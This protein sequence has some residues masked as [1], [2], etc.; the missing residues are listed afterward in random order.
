MLKRMSKDLKHPF[1][2]R[3]LTTYQSPNVCY[4]LLELVQ[5]GELFSRLTCFAMD[6]FPMD[7]AKFYAS[8]TMDALCYIHIGWAHSVPPE[9]C[10][11]GLG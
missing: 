5:G 3:L 9:S 4:F 1:V 11:R 6:A 10:V 7:E 8:T 2:L